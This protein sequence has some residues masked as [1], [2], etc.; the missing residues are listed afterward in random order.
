MGTNFITPAAPVVLCARLI[1]LCAALVNAQQPAKKEFAFRGKVEQVDAAAKRLTV[2]NEPIQGWMG[3]MT[4]AYGVSNEAVLSTLKPGDQ[5]AAKVYE[6]DFTLYDVK[7]VSQPSSSV[8]ATKSPGLGLE[9]LEKMALANNPTVAQVQANF[10]AASQLARQ[11]GLYPNPTIGYYGDEIRGGYSGGGKQGGFVSQTIVL[12]GK[13]GA[14]RR[15]AQ[16]RASEIETSGQVQRLRILN[17]V[18]TVFYQVLAAQRLVEVRQSLLKLAGDTIQTSLQLAN[19]GQAD[20]PDILQAEVERQQATVTLRVAEQQLQASWRVLAAVVGKPD[21]ALTHL[22]GDLEAVP[23]LNYDEWLATTLRDSPEIK[24]AQQAVERAEASLAQARKAPIPDLQVTGILA[25]NYEPLEATR[26]PTGLQGGAQVGVQLPIFNRNQ[27]G[28][29]AARADI[30][31][32][33]QNVARVKLQIQ[34]EL[35]G[36]FRD[37]AAGRVLVQQYKTEM[38]PRAEEAYRLYQTNYQKMAGAYPQ[39]LISQRTLFQLEAEYVQALENTW[40]NA[41]LIRGFGLMDGLSEPFSSISGKDQG[42][43]AGMAGYNTRP[44]TAQ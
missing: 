6:G 13:L 3:A 10:R 27:G 32:A 28:V 23:E 12:G 34:R 4:M 16:I 26:K 1:L 44:A 21:L 18:R 14:A 11:A 31:S 9:A 39:V 7:V 42:G 29:A 38:L 36:M 22:D 41:L 19:V 20:R 25:Q 30:E 24:L 5:I 17:N 40:Q 35:A 37:Y 33:K 15:V 2:A 8:S 43:N